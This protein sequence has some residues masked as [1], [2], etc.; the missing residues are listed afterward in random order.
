[1]RLSG[2]KTRAILE[3]IWRPTARATALEARRLH[4]G[5]VI[6]PESNG[7]IDRAMAVFF[8]APR[9]LTG[10]DV[11]ELQCHGGSYLVHRVCDLAM[12]MGARF[13]EPGEFTRRAFLNRRIDLLEAEAIADLIEARGDAGLRQAVAQ[14]TGALA[15]KFAGLRAALI[16]IRAHLEA[17][18]DFSDEGLN[19][20]SR[21]EIAASIESVSN[22][23]ALLHGT[24]ERGRMLRVG[25]HV[26]IVGRPNVGKSS[27]L[28]LLVGR[29]RA[30]VTG[31]PGTTR[32]VIEE[33]IQCGSYS[34]TL[35]DTAGIRASHDEI[36]ELGIERSKQSLKDCD[37]MIAVFD[38]SLQLTEEDAAI[39]HQ[40]RGKA[41]VALLNKSDLPA[42]TTSHA[43][44]ES[45]IEVPILSFSALRAH[46][47]D[48]LK[49]EMIKILDEMTGS[50]KSEQ[51]AISRERHRDALERALDALAS[52][53]RSATDSMP[54]EIIAVDLSLAADAL[55]QITGE[56]H[57]EDILDAV[58][59]E[60]CI[61]K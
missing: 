17:E 58:F 51:M 18:I 27:V 49:S 48:S 33:S 50:H 11:A 31:T 38:S 53:K 8:T 2:P 4:L 16:S 57:T 61:G 55:G 30:I 32:D 36:E 41:G 43:L 40:V 52:A 35:Q 13:A 21:G 24:Y 54:P 14:M 9:S 47:L 28:N 26:A 5:E 15:D 22:N 12:R 6:D 25:P 39:A 42:K 10:E 3:S 56:I 1:M 29:D 20:P 45:G 34:L 37:L 19:L 44:R 46:G 23:V 60:F 7:V 59:R